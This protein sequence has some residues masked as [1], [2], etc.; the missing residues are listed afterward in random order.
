M[1]NQDPFT[2]N[3]TIPTSRYTVDKFIGIIIDI[4]ASKQSI[5]GYSQFLAF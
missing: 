3:I 4:R 5:I 2:Y 1:T